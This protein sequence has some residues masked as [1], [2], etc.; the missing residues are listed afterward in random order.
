MSQDGGIQQ[1]EP[2]HCKIVPFHMLLSR[3]AG[4]S[5]RNLMWRLENGEAPVA[6]SSQ[7]CIVLS[8]AADLTY[9]SFKARLSRPIRVPN[10]PLAVLLLE[11]GLE[12]HK[13]SWTC[14]SKRNLLRF[15][16]FLGVLLVMP[17]PELLWRLFDFLCDTSLKASQKVQKVCCLLWQCSCLRLV[18]TILS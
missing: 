7:A 12:L 5:T 10:V 15:L 1:N 3:F 2:P 14:A 17:R 16:P 13:A 6:L 9:A 8:G 11:A 18:C 4:D